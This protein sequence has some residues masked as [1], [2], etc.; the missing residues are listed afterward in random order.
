MSQIHSSCMVRAWIFVRIFQIAL[1]HLRS[2]KATQQVNMLWTPPKNPWK[3][4]SPENTHKQW[5]PIVSKWCKVSS[6]K[7]ILAVSLRKTNP[8]EQPKPPIVRDS[9]QLWEP[10]WPFKDRHSRTRCSP[11]PGFCVLVTTLWIILAYCNL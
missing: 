7:S 6:V 10:T 11:P 8:N 5:C 3:D 4:N 1:F 2:R 9:H